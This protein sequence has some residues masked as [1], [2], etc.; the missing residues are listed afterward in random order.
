MGAS[1]LIAFPSANCI[2]LTQAR[3]GVFLGLRSRHP[4]AIGIVQ[5]EAEAEPHKAEVV[6]RPLNEL[7]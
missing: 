6:G 2:I 7:G 3:A 1:S 4:L 5:G